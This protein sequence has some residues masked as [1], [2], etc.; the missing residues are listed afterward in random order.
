MENIKISNFRKIQDTWDLDLAP[1]TFFTGTNNSGKST[2]FKAMLLLEDYVKSPNHFQ[3]D[4]N[5]PNSKKHKIHSY[6]N[7]VNE[8]MQSGSNWNLNFSYSNMGHIVSLRFQPYGFEDGNVIKGRLKLLEVVREKD[9]SKLCIENT[10]GNEYVVR[11]DIDFL[12]DIS[13]TENEDE[14]TDLNR[15]ILN[16]ENNIQI[17]SV[18]LEELISRKN[19]LEKNI[20]HKQVKL[21]NNNLKDSFETWLAENAKKGSGKV[22]PYIRA[23]ELLSNKT[24]SNIFKNFVV[25]EIVELYNDVLIEQKKVGGKYYDEKAPSYGLSGF[26][27][28]ALKLYLEFLKERRVSFSQYRLNKLYK[29]N[30]D[31]AVFRSHEYKNLTR[32][33]LETN[34][35]IDNDKKKLSI[36]KQ[37]QKPFE[38]SE[39]KNKIVLMPEFS[40]DNFDQDLFSIDIIL[41]DIIP[42]Y[43][44][45]NQN[46][47]GKID[48][49][50]ETKKAFEFG[51]LITQILRFSVDHLGPQRH[52]Q[53]HLYINNDSTSA[54]NELIN[55]HSLKP[56]S[57]TS[58]AGKFLKKWMQEF[59]IGEDFKIKSIEGIASQIEI[60]SSGK[61]INLADKGFG[62]GQIFTILLKIALEIQ[63]TLVIKNSKNNVFL[64][65]INIILIEEPEA[66]L[67]PALQ[68]KLADLFFEANKAFGIRF[69]LETHSEYILRQSL[70][71]HV[72][73]DKSDKQSNPF[74]LYY[75]LKEGDPYAMNYLKNGKFDKSF[76]SGFFNVADD[77]AVDIYKANLKR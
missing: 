39:K 63:K 47:F 67:H 57:K 56:I 62:A 3:L 48:N 32:R 71:L 19:H 36:L 45:E 27:S 22:K 4:F 18:Q 66:N 44:S 2:I 34:I 58:K 61:K 55:E 69:I 26:Y 77:L 8:F 11:L 1:I 10:G 33:I 75:F 42:N 28:A 49:S 52:A 21:S 53:N 24:E 68:A 13:K 59:D 46:K 40:L 23:I 25:D 17:N 12:N 50:T 35:N 7:A 54:I 16:V 76:G 64:K 14:L 70:F 37:K 65:S 9:C 74:G 29:N 31:S 5:G 60:I 6:K 72:K 73:I 30:L 38:E 41:R 15:L 43:L 51:D 20:K